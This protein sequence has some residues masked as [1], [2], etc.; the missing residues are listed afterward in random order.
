MNALLVIGRIAFV[1][2]FILSGA[3][4]L[5]DI[6]GTAAMIEAKL[7]VP[8]ILID[9]ETRLRDLTGM[10]LPQLLAITAGVVEI[11]AGVM[12]AAGFGTRIAA[13][14]LILFTVAATFLFHDVWSTSGEERAGNMIQAMKNLSIIGALLVLFVIGR[15]R[16]ASAVRETRPAPRY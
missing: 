6:S 7:V 16:P 12:I 9:V 13:V 14:A 15:W 8:P 11:V 1:A 3:Q 4:K 5:F 2:I 10:P